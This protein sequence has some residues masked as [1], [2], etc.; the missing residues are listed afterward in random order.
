MC[1]S[2]DDYQAHKANAISDAFNDLT[3]AHTKSRLKVH[4]MTILTEDG[5]QM[6]FN[7]SAPWLIRK[8]QV[9][10]IFMI[11]KIC[12]VDFIVETDK[13]IYFIRD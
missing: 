11:C 5:L 6:N 13:S 1:N 8:I 10:R 7:G 2:V 4:D 9:F 3:I 12:Q